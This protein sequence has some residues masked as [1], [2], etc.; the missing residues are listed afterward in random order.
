MMDNRKSK[1]SGR[2]TGCIA[3]GLIVACSSVFADDWPQWRG[4]DR[5]GVWHE[6]GLIEAFD[7]PQIEPVWT[8]E[9]SNGYSGPTVANGRVYLTDR[10][11]EPE[12]VERVLCFDAATG[13]EVWTHVYES[14]YKS[15][16]YRDGPRSSVTLADGRAFALG[17][18]GHF[19]ALDAATGELLWKKDPGTDYNIPLPV[20]GMVAAPLVD[21]DNVIVMMGARDGACI[22]AMDAATGV[23]IWRA[24][25]DRASYSPP[26]IVQQGDQRVLVC[27]TGKQIAGLDPATG[28]VLWTLETE[29]ERVTINIASP[30]VQGNRLFLTAFY[31]G[32][33]MLRLGQDA[34][35]I[36]TIWRRVGRSE[37]RT[38]ALHSINSTPLI[39]GDYVYG[40]DSYGE[41][42]CLDAETGD[43]IWEDLTAVPRAR[44]A[45][46]HMVRNGNRVWMFNERGELIISELSPEGFKEL[47]RT[48]LIE[49]SDGQYTGT[50][51]AV[52]KPD[53][54]EKPKVPITSSTG[55]VW[56][57]PAYANKHVFV[58]NDTHLVCANLAAE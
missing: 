54:D 38:E 41:L 3:A 11:V 52:T 13:E 57:H 20:W 19:R 35:T 49:P 36:D 46:I 32:S 4:P 22:V 14:T 42:R 30:I 15:V 44:W 18:M 8:A 51:S 58:R 50:Y 31:D 43:R 27:W 39:I 28:E 47:S 6:T 26:I 37:M 23:E 25:D 10:V 55:V 53:A 48:K 56:S 29:P 16:G 1:W 9:I 33:Y 2:I 7:G 24:L 21:G 12:E 34:P 17:T 5:D 45:T 40:V